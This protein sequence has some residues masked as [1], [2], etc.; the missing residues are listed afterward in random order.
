MRPDPTIRNV[1]LLAICQGLAMSC[2]SLSIT[3]AALVGSSLADDK[4]LA[5]LPLALQFLGM[6][7]TT[8]PA[9]LLMQRFGRRAGLSLG[10]V[11]GLASGLLGAL[12][13]FESDFALLCVSHLLFGAF[14]AHAQFYRF[15]AADTASPAYRGRAI[16]WVMS[17]GLVAAFL[18]PQLAVWSRHWFDPVLFAG[19]YLAVAALSLLF[20]RIPRPGTEPDG[21]PAR[22]LSMVVR[23]PAFAL[24]VLAGMVS[25]GAMNLVMTATPLAIIACQHPFESAAM[26]IQWHVVGMF[27]PSFF[28][29]HLIARFGVYRVIAAGGLLIV[30]CVAVNLSGVQVIQFWSALLLLGLG[31]NLM[32]VGGTTLLTQTYRPAERAKVQAVNDFLVFSVVATTAFASGAIFHGLGWPA[33]NL[34]ILAP[35]ALTA[36]IAFIYHRRGE[37]AAVASG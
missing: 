17:G 6:V 22:P 11:I 7:A 5:T 24:A 18:G 31:W 37:T 14:T 2:S 12:A 20:I 34:A 35:V 4:S 3:I 1:S 21:V 30:G 9:S 13:L 36:L 32:F 23:Q 27:A 33:I 29:G 8:I 19:G 25:Y 15:A 26:V 28:T 16:S 10:A